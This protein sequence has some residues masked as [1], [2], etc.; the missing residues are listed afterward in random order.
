MCLAEGP[1]IEEQLSLFVRHGH[2]PFVIPTEHCVEIASCF[3]S[4][5]GGICNLLAS[6]A[7]NVQSSFVCILSNADL[8]FALILHAAVVNPS[9]DRVRLSMR[10]RISLVF[11][12][13]PSGTR[14]L[15]LS[16]ISGSV[17][18]ALSKM[19]PDCSSSHISDIDLRPFAL[20]RFLLFLV[21]CGA[22]F[23]RL[24]GVVL[25]LPFKLDMKLIFKML[26]SPTKQNQTTLG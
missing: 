5:S 18:F 7:H 11:C 25:V 22:A 17:F 21:L 20:Q 8:N 12:G 10:A 16:W 26:L 9:P 2:V 24:L 3:Q 23:L 13:T 1:L 14:F 19:I 15:A 4:S 6:D